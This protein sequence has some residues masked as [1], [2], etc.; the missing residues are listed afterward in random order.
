MFDILFCSKF[1]SFCRMWL[2]V[3]VIKYCA[4]MTNCLF[5]DEKVGVNTFYFVHLRC[6]YPDV[7]FNHEVGEL[8]AV[9]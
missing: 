5:F 6:A 8:K 1:Y 7:V 4:D 2:F 9:D 3:I